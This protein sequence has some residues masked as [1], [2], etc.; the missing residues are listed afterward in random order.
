VIEESIVKKVK[1]NYRVRGSPVLGDR[2]TGILV[3]CTILRPHLH[4][5]KLHDVAACEKKM[6]KK[7]I[8]TEVNYYQNHVGL[9]PH[10]DISL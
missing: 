2:N 4:L 1:Y 7:K 6:N 3:L 9:S 10:K 5:F 8:Y